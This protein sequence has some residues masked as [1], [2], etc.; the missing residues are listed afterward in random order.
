MSVALERNL[1]SGP[2]RQRFVRRTA[3]RL[4]ALSIV[5][6]LLAL[7][8]TGAAGGL[9]PALG[10]VGGPFDKLAAAIPAPSPDNAG[11]VSPGDCALQAHCF[12]VLPASDLRAVVW[13][14]DSART[15]RGAELRPGRTT[16]P[17]PPPPKTIHQS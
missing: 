14:L 5:L 4:R 2:T 10:H 17:T 15:G 12:V 11:D 13:T 8:G 3:P 9:A 16:P 7:L 1:H 6:L